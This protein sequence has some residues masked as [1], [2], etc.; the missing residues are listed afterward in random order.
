MGHGAGVAIG[1]FLVL[2]AA[3]V[4]PSFNCAEARNP[5][6]RSICADPALA[7]RDKAVDL[8]YK[9]GGKPFAFPSRY[10]RL[11]R[12]W[13]SRRNRC[14]TSDCVRRVYDERIG[15][16]ALG[17][18]ADEDFQHSNYLARLGLTRIDQDW[19]IFWL[20]M[21]VTAGDGQPRIVSA[22]G[23]IRIADGVGRWESDRGCVLQF[24]QTG[25][26]WRIEQGTMCKK[27]FVG[28]CFGGTYY[29]STDWLNP[30]RVEE[31]ADCEEYASS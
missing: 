27:D 1:A 13:L 20:G 16:L 26:A 7:V 2:A 5:V 23:L 14:K 3:S 28:Q 15:V 31:V 6:E 12:Q 11:Q 24:R 30:A 18:P 8:L 29:T 22:A 21:A 19:H 9:R 17:A 10:V 25:S 4:A